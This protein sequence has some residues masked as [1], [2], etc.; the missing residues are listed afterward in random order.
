MTRMLIETWTNKLHSDEMLGGK[1]EVIFRTRIRVICITQ[2]QIIWLHCVHALL[3][4]LLERQKFFFEAGF[5]AA[6]AGLELTM[7]TRLS[8]NVQ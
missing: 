2:L 5:Y 3:S 7:Y 1:Q 6:L 8:S 4:R